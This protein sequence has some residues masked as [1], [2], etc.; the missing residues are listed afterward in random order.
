MII[1]LVMSCGKFVLLLSEKNK[2]LKA[3]IKLDNFVSETVEQKS[4]IF[5]KILNL[6]IL[7]IFFFQ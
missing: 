6:F 4:N 5:P 2:E 3:T 7:K 1:N